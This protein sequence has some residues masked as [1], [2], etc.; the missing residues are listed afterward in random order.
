MNISQVIAILFLVML[1]RVGVCELFTVEKVQGYIEYGMICVADANI[2]I[3]TGQ[4]IMLAEEYP[5]VKN[6]I[7]SKHSEIGH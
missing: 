1:D 3:I 4:K 7:N 2:Q 6:G 5:C